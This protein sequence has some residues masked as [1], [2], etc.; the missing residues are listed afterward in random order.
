MVTSELLLLTDNKFLHRRAT[1]GKLGSGG[2]PL[3]RDSDDEQQDSEDDQS[4][5][6]QSSHVLAKSTCSGLTDDNRAHPR[7][8]SDHSVHCRLETQDLWDRFRQLG[9]TEMIITKAGR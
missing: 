1:S 6:R 9:L 5:E 4:N 7:N 3:Q 8:A 2:S